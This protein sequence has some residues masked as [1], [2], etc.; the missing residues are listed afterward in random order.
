MDSIP[1][2]HFLALSRL[3]G[4]LGS[5]EGGY[6]TST[7]AAHDFDVD[8]RTG[9]MPPQAPPSRLPADWESWELVLDGAIA[10]SL[11]L[12]DK[13]GL[14]QA[15]MRRSESWR[16]GV[17]QVRRSFFCGRP[18]LAE[19]VSAPRHPDF[20]VDQVGDESATRAPRPGMDDAL[21]HPLT[22]SGRAGGRPCPDHHP[23]LPDIHAHAAAARPHVCGHGAV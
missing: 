19:T 22:A 1:P 21:L 8:N 5:Q 20:R 11:Q 12:G 14:T 9:F 6:D 7:L 2:D 4:L 18:S 16:H 10:E 13:P 17:R 15:E 3:D 23:P